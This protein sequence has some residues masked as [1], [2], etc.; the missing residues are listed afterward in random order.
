MQ[1]MRGE[2]GHF[3]TLTDKCDGEAFYNG[4]I[5]AAG[6][7]HALVCTTSDPARRSRECAG[8]ALRELWRFSGKGRSVSEDKKRV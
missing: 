5:I 4:K 7:L 2:R 8:Q 3:S 6:G 1:K